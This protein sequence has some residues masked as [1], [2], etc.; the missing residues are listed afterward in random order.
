MLCCVL[1]WYHRLSRVV[2]QAAAAASLILIYAISC[3]HWMFS[4]PL[5]CMCVQ[6]IMHA[7][8]LLLLHIYCIYMQDPLPDT[9]PLY[10]TPTQYPMTGSGKRITQQTITTLHFPLAPAS[11]TQGEALLE[12]SIGEQ[13]MCLVHLTFLN[14]SYYCCDVS[15]TVYTV[16]MIQLVIAPFE[17]HHFIHFL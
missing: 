11:N 9:H 16:H 2:S 8:I 6:M 15:C 17:R 10:E 7:Y 5:V 14:I 12:L 1:G 4:K 3:V 13:C